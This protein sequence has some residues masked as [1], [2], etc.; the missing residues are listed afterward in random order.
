[1]VLMASLLRRGATATAG[2]ST[3]RAGSCVGCSTGVEHS[4]HLSAAEHEQDGGKR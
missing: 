2:L 4:R 1:M 3:A